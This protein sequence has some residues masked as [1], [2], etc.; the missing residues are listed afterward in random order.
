MRKFNIIKKSRKKSKDIDEKIEYL[1]NECQKTGLNEITMGTGGVYQGSTKVPNQNYNDFSGLS[2]G[3]YGFGLSGGDG[4]GA[5]GASVGVI[6]DTVSN[7]AG[8][9]GLSGVAI[10]PP[11]PIT[12]QRKCARTQTG[13]AGFFSPLRPGQVQTNSGIPSGGALWFF[14]PL[15]NFGG[16]QGRWLNFQ[17]HPT[18]NAWAFWDTNFLGFFFLNTNLDQYQLHGNNLGTE[19]KNKILGLNFGTNGAI[20][21]PQTTVLTKNDLGNPTF[22]PINIP[23]LSGEAYNYLKN[24]ANNNIASGGVNYDL[25]NY[26]DKRYGIEAS[27]WYENNPTLPHESN[28]FIPTPEAPY[29]PLASNPNQPVS[30]TNIPSPYAGAQDGD[31]FAFFGGGNNKNTPPPPPTRRTRKGSTDATKASTGMYPSMTPE[32]FQQ[33]YGISYSEYLKLP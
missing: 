18:Q 6:D 9:M 19:I 29:V 23:D 21:E 16:E 5:G 24:K 31:E 10:S 13:F 27:N 12:G 33:K 2:Q 11:H 7:C 25:Y 28:P 30:D 3:G 4:N 8:H 26:L 17:W 1:N 32:I 14:D 20:G 22:L 15:Y